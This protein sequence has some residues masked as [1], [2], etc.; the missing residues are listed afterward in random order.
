ER[1]QVGEIFSLWHEAVGERIVTAHEVIEIAGRDAHNYQDGDDST[2]RLLRALLGVA[3][4]R[5]NP[6][7]IDPRRLGAWCRANTDRIVAGLKLCR[8][9]ADRHHAATW[10]VVSS[11]RSVSS[12]TAAQNLA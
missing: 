11:G 9:S 2:H 1:D 8:E 5:E 12:K 10:R 6:E 3:A 4:K 7:Q